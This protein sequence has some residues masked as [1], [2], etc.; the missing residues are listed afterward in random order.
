MEDGSLMYIHDVWCVC[1]SRTATLPSIWLYGGVKLKSSTVSS[2]V[3]A[4]W[5]IKIATVTHPCTSPVR[6]ETSPSSWRSA[7]PKPAWTWPTRW[8]EQHTPSCIWVTAEKRKNKVLSCFQCGWM[9]WVLID[10]I[11]APVVK[12]VFIVASAGSVASQIHDM[13]FDS[14]D[15]SS[16]T[17]FYS[18]V[19]IS[20]HSIL[21][22]LVMGLLFFTHTNISSRT[23]Q[24]GGVHQQTTAALPE[25]MFAFLH[26]ALKKRHQSPLSLDVKDFSWHN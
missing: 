21:M 17:H 18:D 3:V 1:V 16:H 14:K 23:I 5:T 26:L 8:T 20:T 13:Q 6:T 25:V 22:D 15:T 2:D 4:A 10:S 12:I 11:C 7:T 9:Y 24:T 19:F